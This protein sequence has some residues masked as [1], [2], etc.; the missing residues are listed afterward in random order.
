MKMPP[1]LIRLSALIL[2]L[3]AGRQV[4][5]ADAPK[6]LLVV[7]V[8]MGFRHSSISAAEATLAQLARESGQFT[9]EFVRQPEGEPVAPTPPRVGANGEND[10][11]D[12]AA[13]QKFAAD[14]RAYQTARAAW[15]AEVVAVLQRLSPASLANFDG[16]IFANTTGDLPLPDRQGFVDWVASG[17]AFIGTHSASDTFHEF[18]PYVAMLG[19]EFRTHGPQVTAQCLNHDPAHAACMPLPAAWTVYDE[20]YEFNGF[21]R[22]RVHGLLSLDRLALDGDGNG[23][24]PGDYPISW[25]RIHGNGRVFYTALG[26]R[27]DVW[28]PLDQEPGG[29][30]NPPAVARQF[31]Q[32]L[33]GGILWALGLAPGSTIQSKYHK[34]YT[35]TTLA[36]AAGVAG[37]AN[38]TGGAARFDF[39]N[40]IAVDASGNVY[41]TER[42][43]GTVRKIT[44]DGIVTTVAGSP[45]QPGS[46]DGTGTAARFAAPSGIAVDAVGNL[47][48]ADTGNHTI[49]KITAA[50]VVSTL[51]GLA[52][53]SGTTNGTG[54]A[55]RF[56]SPRGI[57]VDGSGNVYVAEPMSETIRRITPSG[58]V[59]TFAGLAGSRGN[60]DGAGSAARFAG[61]SGITLDGTGNLFVA[62]DS[63]TIRKITSQGVVTTLAGRTDSP[64][65][66]DGIAASSRFVSPREVAV[67][68]NGNVYVTDNNATIR[69]ITASGVVSTLAGAPD[70]RGRTEGIGVDARFGPAVGVAV[71][72][73]GTLYIADGPNH[74]IRRGVPPSRV[75]N[76]SVRAAAGTGDQTLIVGFTIGETGSKQIVL[77]GVGPS[78]A[79]F[80]VSGVL[81]DPQLRLFSDRAQINQNDDWDGTTALSAAFAA[82][83]AFALPPGSKDAAL[84]VP[85]SNGLYTAQMASA[86]GSGVALLEVYDADP[87]SPSATIANV[88]A[89]NH[90]GTGDNVLIVGF[91]VSG[92]AE[93]TLLIRAVGPTLAF[94]VAGSLPDPKLEVFRGST[95]LQSNDD[96]GGTT[97]LSTVFSQVGAFPL[98]G[99]SK[100]AA[101]LV[102][103][104]PGSYTAQV[105]GAGGTTGVALI[106]VF[107]LP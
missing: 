52:G 8:T 48:V 38:G 96:W 12:Q 41:V 19:G 100:D 25:S 27:E 61:P 104:Q 40:G 33:L 62:S 67:D 74:T 105:S 11:A 60:G 69:R 15:T 34:A 71:D 5:A 63:P 46:A 80:N 85:L 97:T 53:S 70:R 93:K 73:S 1:R 86:A 17:K 58:T 24:T 29:R 6:K 30:R 81:G 91:A 55:A 18:P 90:V 95:L 37:G 65:T 66:D 84:F 36:G 101:L 54:S 4:Y 39:P 99:T 94:A 76:L 35:F 79:R 89:R 7:T 82:V 56:S 22:S 68:G 21:E 102:T 42:V 72:G 31:Q 28:D 45:M 50:G 26:H 3:A 10:P 13:L 77:R 88:S 32:H 9:V 16:V 2:A 47:Y 14:D 20:I 75:A 98:P 23:Q 107:E 83:G 78:L 103:L 64:G 59:T 49:R 87:G 44:V 43:N 92:L 106:E 57:A 51:A